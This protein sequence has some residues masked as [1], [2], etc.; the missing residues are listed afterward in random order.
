MFSSSLSITLFFFGLLSL[1]ES[2]VSFC[3]I[4]HY[5]RDKKIEGSLFLL[6]LQDR[7]CIIA[8]SI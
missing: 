1:G 2:V 5:G 6:N 3:V 4:D 7:R 8:T